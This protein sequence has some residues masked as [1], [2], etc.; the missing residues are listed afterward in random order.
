MGHLDG[1]GI[2]VDSTVVVNVS[3]NSVGVLV[4]MVLGV[5]IGVGIISMVVGEQLYKRNAITVIKITRFFF[6]ILY[7]FLYIRFHLFAE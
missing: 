3:G 4:G 7:S 5:R 6:L 1:S 2:L